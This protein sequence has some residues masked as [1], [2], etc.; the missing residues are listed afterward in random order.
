MGK[1]GGAGTVYTEKPAQEKA[2][3]T[4]VKAWQRMPTQLLLE[5]T[6]QQ[7]KSKPWYNSV[8]AWDK[9]KYRQKVYIEDPKNKDASLEFVC[10]NDSDSLFEAKEYAALVALLKLQGSMPLERKLPE[11]YCEIWKASVAASAAEAKGKGRGKDAAAPKAEAKAEAKAA[12]PEPPAPS[13]DAG[14][15]KGKSAG[16]GKGEAADDFAWAAAPAGEDDALPAA[17]PGAR[18]VAPLHAMG[19]YTSKA[20]RATAERLRDD[21]RRRLRNKREAERENKRRA[22]L[23]APILL[24]K[25]MRA[26][27]H[28]A[29]GLGDAYSAAAN[30]VDVDMEMDEAE[31]QAVARCVEWGFA[32][33]DALRALAATREE[34]GGGFGGSLPEQLRKWLC[35]HVPEDELPEEFAAGRGQFE[36]RTRATAIGKA[37]AASTKA[38]ARSEFGMAVETIVGWL[39]E[40][41]KEH[42]NAADAE[43]LFASTELVLR[44]SGVEQLEEEELEE[45]GENAAAILE[46]ESE[47]LAPLAAELQERWRTVLAV[48]AA[49]AAAGGGA[50]G[51]GE[52]AAKKAAAEAEEDP[53]AAG[54]SPAEAGTADG[55]WEETCGGIA[56][57]PSSSSTAGRWSKGSDRGQPTA[58]RP[59]GPWFGSGDGGWVAGAHA[60]WAGSSAGQRMCKHRETL[61]AAKSREELLKLIAKS[62]VVLVQGETGC[63]KTTQV[64]QFL[65]EA[66]E[67]ARVIVTQPRRVAASS[68]AARVAEERGERLGQGV[69]GYSVRGETQLRRES[70]RLLFCT[71]GIL[72]RRLLGEPDD[73]FSD[74]TCTHLVIDEVHER[75][76]EIDLLL[77]LLCHRLTNR[78]KLRVLLMSATMDV[79]QLSSMF[80]TSPPIVKMP[81]RTFPVTQLY[82]EDAEETLGLYTKQP[83]DVDDGEYEAA[84]DS[85]GPQKAAALP[86]YLAP[87]DFSMLSKLVFAAARGELKD[88]PKDGAILVFLPGVGEISRLISELQWGSDTGGCRLQPLPLHGGLPPDQQRRCFEVPPMGAPRKVVVSTNVAETSVTVPDVT[89]VIDSA[90]ERRLCLDPGA[91]APCLAERH[92]S[93]S[94]LRQRKGRAGRVQAGLCLTL[95]PRREALSLP[96]EA[97]PE[98]ESAPLESLCLQVRVAGFDPAAF[99]ARA[100]TPPERAR[101][102]AA[103]RML[104]KIGATRPTPSSSSTTSSGKPQVG[105]AALGRHLASLPCDVHIGKLLV[106]GAF[107]GVA[108][109]AVDVAAMLSVRSPLKSTQ[110][111]QAVQNWRTA[112]RNTLRPG[113]GKSDHCL[114]AAIMQLWQKDR[115]RSGRRE[116]CQKAG[117][118]FERMAEADTVRQ[119]LVAGLRGLGFDVGGEDDRGG[120]EWRVLRA[121]ICAAFFPQV[122]RVDRPP[123]EYEAVMAGAIE[124]QAEARRLRYFILTDAASDATVGSDA[125]GDAGTGWLWKRQESTRRV[126]LH[127]S[128][129]L[130]KESS[131]SCPYV[132]FSSKQAQEA[133]GDYPSRV[134]LSE[135][136]EASVYALLLFG[137]RLRA[138]TR[139]NEV[140]VD[141]WITFSSGSTTVVA[142]V[143]RL[144]Q[145][146]DA[147]LSRKVECP[148]LSVAGSA[149]AR[150]VTTLL[151]T[152]GLGI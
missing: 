20:E 37:A 144:R 150:A 16:R 31:S 29:L 137:G 146:I 99:L 101:V 79:E 55:F 46:A 10:A 87:I 130:F 151:S 135:A 56:A 138:D 127:P 142:L 65:I 76:V 12:P 45:A 93:Q 57:E 41:L 139:R 39:E 118:V 5:W 97:P 83:C 89:I 71:N 136:S 145:E 112:L 92:C 33:T 18:A 1:R 103:E 140:S 38:V 66:D 90:R 43:A 108:S 26:E 152:D 44:G 98:I 2:D 107:L 84:W 106:L 149:V 129:L 147:L 121:A 35:L 53:T 63:G 17:A 25:R 68:V 105:V 30:E 132:I 141:E 14:G 13:R 54:A 48:R 42:L 58:V 64:G 111:D 67:H 123:K 100:P 52:A 28:G 102:E 23:D 73:M 36:V 62:Q 116:L 80:T 78:P 86:R 113:G 34:A 124:K 74:R 49:A 96:K 95:L 51:P 88:C 133:R 77:T 134:N 126:F 3:G 128:S 70:C 32:S 4:V 110:K 61:P 8:R 60:T 7:K 40:Q 6:Q 9:D 119:Q 85:T 148:H 115:S 122:A 94:S 104:L 11:P 82:L 15:P 120:S 143:E 91:V 47:E 59:R 131:Y 27:I 72:L 50:G 22:N 109:A 125:Q 21:E 69:V 24:S 81:G 19:Q 75:S 114:S 117:L